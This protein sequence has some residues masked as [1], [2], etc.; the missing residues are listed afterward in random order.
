MMPAAVVGNN[1]GMLMAIGG[2]M[3]GNSLLLDI[4]M[5]L[6]AGGVLMPVLTLP[7]EFDASKRALQQLESLKLVDER[8][9][10]GARSMLVAA[11]LTYVAGAATSLIFLVMIAS[12]FIGRR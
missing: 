8:D 11:A 6:F 2:G 1:I 3:L 5:L 9:Y 7:I 10:D 12:R 4:G